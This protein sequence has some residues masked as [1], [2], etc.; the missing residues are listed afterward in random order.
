VETPTIFNAALNF[1][2]NWEGNFR[3]LESQAEHALGDPRIMASSADEVVRKLR[4][5]LRLI[6]DRSGTGWERTRSA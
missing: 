2:L 5:E 3:A 1:R 6:P 4:A